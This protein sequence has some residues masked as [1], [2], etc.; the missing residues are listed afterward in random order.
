MREKINFKPYII[1]GIISLIIGAGLTCAIFFGF[2]RSL[3]DGFSIS[4]VLLISAGLL[5]W[6]SREGFF[7]LLTYGFRQLGSQL[8]SKKPNEYNN[9]AEY[10]QVYNEYREKRS[11]YFI[12]VILI[13]AIFLIVT[14]ILSVW[15]K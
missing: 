14:I 10:K 15:A 3:S 12:S 6:V 9:F 11:K 8:F 5:I 1:S 2:K 7:D 4:A 13:G